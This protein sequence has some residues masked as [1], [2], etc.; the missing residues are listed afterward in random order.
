MRWSILFLISL[1]LA[2][3]KKEPAAPAEPEQAAEA[4]SPEGSEALSPELGAPTEPSAEVPRPKGAD[5]LPPPLRVPAPPLSDP[6]IIEVL[7]QGQAPRRALQWKVESGFA[8]KLSADV[9][10]TIDAVVVVMRVGEAVYVVSY[11]L[12]L[13]AAKVASDGS[14]RVAYEVEDAE[15]DLELVGE[16]RV[17]R[18]KR[19]LSSARELSGSYTLGPRGRITDFEMSIPEGTKRTGHDMADNLR[20]AITQMTPVFPEQPLGQGAKW[21]VQQ[22]VLQGG[23]HVNQLTTFTIKKL[24]G[25]RV[26]LAMDQLQSAA[27]QTF[28]DPGLPINKQLNLLSG[29]AN[30]PLTWK[31]S[32]LA[33]GAADLGSGVLKAAEQPSTDPTK[34]PVEA[35]IQTNRALQ[36]G[37]K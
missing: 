28:Q 26:E 33:P 15:V 9:G 13:R 20:W 30:G 25:E 24:E 17:E 27:K 1:S 7:D 37:V 35:L 10:F 32:E 22:G 34:R 23:I 19:A 8:Q 18:I 6:P 21:T 4:A 16:K 3:T 29:M 36:I 11:D 2:C 12:T 5:E 14:V 31:L